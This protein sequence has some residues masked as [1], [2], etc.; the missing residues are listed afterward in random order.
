MSSPDWA[1]TTQL[2]A[3]CARA[4]NKLL[5]CGLWF[6]V[7]SARNDGEMLTDHAPF[8]RSVW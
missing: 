2:W 1:H 5:R 8:G 7:F 3:Q 6:G 4:V